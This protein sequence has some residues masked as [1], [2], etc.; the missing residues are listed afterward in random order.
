PLTSSSDSAIP[1]P[2]HAALLQKYIPHELANKILSAGAQIE[3][4]RRLVTV[5]FADVSGFTAMSEKLDA[6]EVTTVIN[7]CFKGL[8]S[9]V[10]KYEG[11]IDKFIGDEIMAIFGAPLTHENDPER[12]IRCSMEMMEYMER[13]NQLSPTALPE[14]LGIHIAMNT[15]MVVAGNVGSDLRM[16]YSVIG[17]TVNLASRLKHVAEKGEIVVSE[18][19]YRIISSLVRADSPKS[20]EIKGKSEPVK[21]YKIFSL[22]EGI[23]PGA[24]IS[25]K[26]PII[27]RDEEIATLKTSLEKVA[28]KKEQ[29]LFIRGEAGVG[30]TRLKL[31]LIQLAKAKSITVYEGKCS[32]FEMNTPYYLWT[33]LL[34]DI[35]QL[36]ADTG[37]NETRKR[38]HDM[39][40]ILSMEKHEPYLA[41]LL[42]LRYEE[43]L[44][45]EDQDRKKKIFESLK[46]FIR[47]LAK[48]KPSVFLLEDVHWIDRFSQDMLEYLFADEQLAQ[49]MFVPLFRDEYTH[50]KELIGKGGTLIDLNRLTQVDA[51]KLMC[52]RLN[53]TEISPN[54][55]E[56]IYKRSE[57]NPFFIEELV[58]TIIDKNVVSV[59]GQ[60]LEILKTD[61]ESILPAT[62]QGVIM[63]RIDRLEEKL[64]DVLYGASVIGREFDKNLLKEIIKKKDAVDLSLSELL[65]LEMILEKEEAKELAYLFKHYLIQE[66]AYNTILQKKRRALHKLIAQAIEKVY[67]D[68]LKEFYE[69]L[70]FHYE[71][72]EEWEKAAEYLALSGRKVEEMYSEEE[73]KGFYE[74]KTEAVEK[75]YSSG[76]SNRP[77]VKWLIRIATIV[78][79]LP[80]CIAMVLTFPV[81]IYKMLTTTKMIPIEILA[82][83]TVVAI[84]WIPISIMVTVIIFF[85]L[86]NLSFRKGPALYEVMEDHVVVRKPNGNEFKVHFSEL[87]SVLWWTNSGLSY[88]FTEYMKLIFSEKLFQR[89]YS[90]ALYASLPR[91]LLRESRSSPN[92]GTLS[93]SAREGMIFLMKRSGISSMKV[94]LT[95]WNILNHEKAISIGLTPSN[96]MAFHEQLSSAYATWRKK[97][98]AEQYEPSSVESKPILTV[99]PHYDWRNII[100]GSMFIN[101][102][103][104][105]LAVLMNALMLF[106]PPPQSLVQQLWIGLQYA[107]INGFAAWITYS[108]FSMKRCYAGTRY[109]FYSDKLKYIIGFTGTQSGEIYYRDMT[110]LNYAANKRLSWFGLGAIEIVTAKPFDLLVGSNKRSALYLFDI[111]DAQALYW[112][113]NTLIRPQ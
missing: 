59:K 105:P 33:T 78:Y 61:F 103:F 63:A 84:I 107:V 101:I 22:K 35:L 46:E 10:Y 17:D 104:Y 5:M 43:I 69:L 90:H 62:V 55:S 100:V 28:Q 99:S 76:P 4:E 3:S 12:A 20:I 25:Q 92:G 71:K 58:K 91:A 44:L 70:S 83:N 54:L 65:S 56:L 6:E 97:K 18:E 31:E 26:N 29:R 86:Y 52:A 45:E 16:N 34:K 96:P 8:I 53:V 110:M 111:K 113:L 49:A 7:D 51:Q 112:T 88:S 24:R 109:E 68:K 73:S 15:G 77:V 23:E 85:G 108:L 80:M 14:P 98:A 36:K 74:R 37:E 47:A 106:N 39:L 75:L 40:Q 67:A 81:L 48:R 19:T 41:T 79:I 95:P 89:F 13:F 21:V 102:V 66:V 50:S 94:M 2:D 11:V 57:G 42:S 60:K 27:G 87:V 30:K 1:V 93:L 38:L 9:I 64:K 32:S 72:A 82:T